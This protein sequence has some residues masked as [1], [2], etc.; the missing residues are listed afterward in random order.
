MNE[1]LLLN[2]I[3][4]VR[5]E[6]K[7]KLPTF[8][9]SKI[10]QFK[11]CQYAYDLKYNQKKYSSDTSLALELGSLCHLALEL[12]GKSLV[13]G[14]P[15]DYVKL[16]KIIH[17]GYTEL[18]EKTKEELL[19]TE[20]L[21]KKYFETWYEKDNASEMTYE[22]K[23]KLFD[24]VLH[25]EMENT[26]WAPYLFEEPFEFVYDNRVI[27]HGFIDRIDTKDGEYRTVDYKTSK[28][29]FDAKAL[30]TSLQFGIYALAILHKFGK[31]PIESL[32][33]FILIDAEQKALT[34][35]WEN[36]LIK[37]LDKVF[38][39]IDENE[40][41]KIWKPS[42]CPL[43]YYCNYCANNPNAKEF[44][45]DCDYYSLWKPNEKTFA[46][47]CEWNPEDKKEDTTK[48]KLVF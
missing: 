17:E 41:S 9:Y 34:L 20:A 42:P 4:E 27:I 35:G 39:S 10:D 6:D 3:R 12:K 45:G 30:P 21:K 1:E 47:N 32:Y 16:N 25:E 43:C 22:D 38:N 14:E 24:K 31:L 11:N 15:I 8:S 18:N 26:E 29:V 44:K 28:K 2:K 13:K 33:R 36:R 19:G 46:V 37:A 7:K 23:M 48:R 5:E 40:K